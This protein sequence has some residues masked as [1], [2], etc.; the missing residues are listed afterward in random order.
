MSVYLTSG[1]ALTQV[2]DAIRAKGGT[3]QPL[4]YPAGFV[5]AI[6]EI[7]TGGTLEK[8]DV[9]FYDYD[10]TLLAA[11]SAQ[12]FLALTELPAPPTHEGL[13]AQGWN[14]TLAQAQAYV[15]AH[16]MLDIGQ[17][18]VPSDGA[19]RIWIRIEADTP[20][21]RRFFQLYLGETVDGGVTIH[22]GDGQTTTLSGTS[23]T[24]YTHD[25][26]QAGDYVIALEVTDGNLVLSG[27]ST[28]S[29]WGESTASRGNQYQAARIKRLAVGSGVTK[30]G[31][32]AFK[33]CRNLQAVSLPQGV[34]VSD[35]GFQNCCGLYS[36]TIPRGVT[37][38]GISALQSCSGLRAVSL[39]NGLTQIS[40][41]CFAQCGSLARATIPDTVT[42]LGG[43]VFA[44]CVS[45][46]EI[47]LSAGLTTLTNNLLSACQSLVRVTIPDS[48]T[49]LATN[50]LNQCSGL[51]RLTIPAGV[52]SIGS[53]AIGNLYGVGELW[54][55]PTTP[56]SLG[57]ASFPSGI[58]FVIYVPYSADHSVFTAY[59]QASGWSSYADKMVEAS[60]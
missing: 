15:T 40:D 37:R 22:W 19:T 17:M 55:L 46:A 59:Q 13:T 28:R 51:T 2:A 18:Y 29:V 12:D 60:R 3:S 25:Y 20:A 36:L 5:A 16:G 42:T 24:L 21:S 14:W 44:S 43:G 38:I 34:T 48:V 49:A 45:L 1:A 10:G 41:Y 23:Q 31:E 47:A 6:G 8:N 54:L 4:T 7:Q 11:Y 53:G 9:N 32:Y 27:S 50:C 33:D 39:P 26:A 57:T 58:S 56:P 35:Y 30:V 52:A